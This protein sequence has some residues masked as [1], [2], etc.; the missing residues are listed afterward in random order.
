M[1]IA[2][3]KKDPG[4][5]PLISRPALAARWECHVETIK[6]WERQGLLHPVGLSSR[7][8]RYRMAEVLAIEQKA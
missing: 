6:R 1:K 2:K 5:A 3:V 7:L 4:E 8:I